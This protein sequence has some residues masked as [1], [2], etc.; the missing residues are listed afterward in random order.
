MWR[1]LEN[2]YNNAYKY[3]LEGTRIYVNVEQNDKIV[4]TMKNISKEE[5]NITPEE[6]ME[7]FVRGDKSRTSGVNGLRSFNS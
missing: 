3:S 4:F 7:R 1:V 6:L 5:L 2:I